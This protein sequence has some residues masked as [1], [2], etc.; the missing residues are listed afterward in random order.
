MPSLAAAEALRLLA[1]GNQKASDPAG[2]ARDV[3]KGH[4]SAICS[5]AKIKIP[6]EI[7]GGL[8]FQRFERVCEKAAEHERESVGF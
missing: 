8:F 4:V 2:P 6:G 3:P 1:Q 7:R 5:F